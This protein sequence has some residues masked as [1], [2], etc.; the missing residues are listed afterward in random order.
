LF[1]IGDW[2]LAGEELYG[3]KAYAEAEQLF[4]LSYGTLRNIASVT[5]NLSFRNDKLSFAHH[6]AV[7]PLPAEKQK[8]WLE[9]AEYGG[10]S[11]AD[12]RGSIKHQEPQPDSPKPPTDETIRSNNESLRLLAEKRGYSVAVLKHNIFYLY[13]QQPDIVQELEEA[14]SKHELNALLHRFERKLHS[15][16]KFTR[17]IDEL[18]E[19]FERIQEADVA[20]GGSGGVIEPEDFKRQWEERTGKTFTF[21]VFKRARECS[22]FQAHFGRSLLEEFGFVEEAGRARKPFRRHRLSKPYWKERW[23]KRDHKADFEELRK[24][25]GPK[26]REMNDEERQ[27]ELV[28]LLEQRKL[29]QQLAD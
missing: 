12:L 3:R 6:V 11:V 17:T 16:G 8:E 15:K 19:H 18:I 27:R 28:K 13:F 14:R 2:L 25:F 1:E 4:K 20:R 24:R 22:Q 29:E 5:K 10:L 9:R 7:A 23:Y 21:A 26:W